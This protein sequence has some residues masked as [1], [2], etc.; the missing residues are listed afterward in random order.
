MEALYR[1]T[2]EGPQC[3]NQGDAHLG[4]VFFERDGTP[5]LLDWQA[6]IRCHG[7]VDATYFLIGAVTIE[8][9][10]RHERELI[11]HYLESLAAH[12]VKAPPSFDEAWLA[13]RSY[14]LHGF[15]WTMTTGEFHPE[16]VI[17]AYAHRYGAAAGDLE[18]LKALGI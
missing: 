11:A 14:A 6:Y 2:D 3:F 16:D 13:Y 5:G 10:R 15:A 18:T 12:G 1:I 9:R 4:N 17:M 7:M 8:D